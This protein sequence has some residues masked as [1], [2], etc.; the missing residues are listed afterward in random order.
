MTEIDKRFALI[1]YEGN[2]RYPYIKEQ[3]STNRRGYA[4]TAP[5]ESDRFSGGTYTLSLEEVVKRLVHDGWSVRA[6]TIDN[7]GKR[8]QGNTVKIGGSKIKGYEISE[9]LKYL[10]ESALIKPLSIDK[11]HDSKGTVSNYAHTNDKTIIDEVTY[12]SIKSRRGQSKFR[13]SLLKA[14]N[15]QCCVTGCNVTAVLE[16]AHIKFHSDETDYSVNN[17]LLLRA[18]IHT[19]FD[20]H[21]I[22]INSDFIVNCNVDDI[23]SF[24]I[25]N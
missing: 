17:G 13:K 8:S 3:K 15:E 1:D 18:D 22:T 2:K 6:V 10:V 5:G 25:W 4:L 14:Y 16:S 24:L 11:P 23:T 19:L 20:L 9:D 12:Q 7:K 21:Q